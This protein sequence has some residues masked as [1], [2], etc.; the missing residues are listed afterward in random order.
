VWVTIDAFALLKFAALGM[1]TLLVG[2]ATAWGATA[3][4]YQV[5]GGRAWKAFAVCVWLTF[6][7]ALL[8]ATWRDHALF[9]LTAYAVGFALLL[10]WWHRIAPSNDRLW[11]DD[12][13]QMSTGS[14]SGNRVTLRNVRNFDWRTRTD[15]TPRWETRSYDLQEL[16]SVDMILSYWTGPAIA[17]MLISFGFES[18]EYV[19]FSVEI[20]RERNEN[21]SEVGGFFKQ[22]ELSIIACDERDVVRVRTNVRKEDAYLYR[23]KMPQAAMRSLFLGYIDQANNLIQTPRFY[24]TITVNCTTLVYHMMKRIVGY[25]P[26]DWRILFTGH[27]AAY[28]Y[29]VGGLDTRYT[30]DELHRMGHITERAKISDRSASFSRDIRGGIPPLNAQRD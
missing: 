22:F 3:L 17:H 13:A 26:L 18:G 4:W 8:V 11:A 6:C 25:L 9:S 29:R 20:R 12:V 16:V 30:L 5:R 24:N 15:Y 1:A 28:V 14:A 19:V 23:M 10:W 7:A 21:F 2:I 27:L